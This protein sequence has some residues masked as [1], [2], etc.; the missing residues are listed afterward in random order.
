MHKAADAA[1][2]VARG[3][4]EGLRERVGAYVGLTK[5]RIIELL[6][7]TT[8][9]AMFLAAGGVPPLPLL[10]FTLVGGTLS[11]AGANVFNSV[12]DRDIDERMHRTRRRPMVRD[13][14]STRN[15]NVFGLTLAVVSTLLL[16]FGANWLS[17]GL[18]VIAILYY[19]FVYT[20][21]LKRRT[22]QN[23]VWGG[24]A[25]CFP[26]LIGWTAV[27]NA[28]ALPPLILFAVVFLWTPAHTWAL[29]L[30]Y[31]D[32]YARADVPMLPVVAD[33]PA[34]TRQILAYAVLTAVVALTLWPAAGTG[35]LYPVVA[36][37]AGGW[38]VTEAVRLKRRADA[39]LTDAALNPLRL[40]HTTNSYL[41][42]VAVAAALD[43]LLF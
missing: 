6:I 31:R 25:G 10:A 28:I 8:I 5:P 21:W 18:S 43:P 3:R 22:P 20:I 23:I 14:V 7:V 9:P 36:V 38:M 34:V 27:T 13:R 35:W 15:A 26:P 33:A 29:G 39:G 2:P 17:A 37:L 42:L 30:R 11:A 24:V 12:Y 1:A 4:R 41:A 40:F 19:V 16:G 32:D